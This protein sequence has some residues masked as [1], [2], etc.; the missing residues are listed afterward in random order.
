MGTVSDAVLGS[1]I[2]SSNFTFHINIG[3]NDKL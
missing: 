3:P 2:L 1:I